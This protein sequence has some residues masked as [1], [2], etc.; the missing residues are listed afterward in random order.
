MELYSCFPAAVR[1]QVREIGI[2]E[3]R[4]HTVTGGM[5]FGGGPLNN[6]VLQ[7]QAKMTHCLRADP[8]SV[9]L[10]TAVS[11][12]LTKQGIGLWSTELRGQGFA[13]ADVSAATEARI[14]AVE[15]VADAS[16]PAKIASYT[17]L[18]DAGVAA[19][20]VMLCDLPDG[21]R[22][23]AVKHDP[24]FA[25]AMTQEEFCGRPVELL[26]DNDVNLA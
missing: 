13:Y 11:G 3:D 21:R 16:G 23:L 18:Y 6:F 5:A 24:D 9:G 7:A 14:E 15:V 8:G 2:A 20:A 12:V 26:D 10:V 19:R 4:P 1:S 25:E 17:V 22:K